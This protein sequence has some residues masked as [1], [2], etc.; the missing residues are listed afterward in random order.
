MSNQQIV[1][2]LSLALLMFGIRVAAVAGD[3][4]QI[5]GPHRNGTAVGEGAVAPWPKT[6]PKKLWSS[7]LGTGFAGPA[8]VGNRVVAFHR[9]GSKERV[10]CFEVDSGKSLW[11]ADFP[12][13][14]P[15]GVNPDNG[16]RC[17]PVV[18]QDRVF[19]FG[20]AGE[21]HCVALSDGRKLWSRDTYSDYKGQVGYFGAGATPIV[22]A[23]KLLVNVGGNNAGI[24]AFDIQTGK[25]AWQATDERAS[26]S[27]PTTATIDGRPHVVFV[28]RLR[29][30]AIDPATGKVLFELPFGKTGPTVNAA[31]PLVLGENLF[32]SASYGVGARLLRLGKS[33]Q[34]IWSND[35]T[36]SSQYSTSVYRDGDLYGIHGREDYSNGELRC[37]EAATGKVRWQVPGFGVGSLI[38]VGDRLVILT[39]DGQLVLAAA[40]RDKYTEL[41]RAAVSTDVTRSLPAISNGRFFFRD[42]N[43]TGGHLTCLTLP[44]SPGAK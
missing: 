33:P 20:A 22:A 4:P 9:I 30:L 15:G 32:L 1:V 44:T 38:L 3:W 17:V 14:Y 34:E 31:T 16:P 6:G 2:R 21:L 35:E 29:C 11:Q 24:V 23:E 27:S 41:A 42:N 40:N 12:G 25:T 26:Y 36:M 39:T 19:V 37:V 13:S 7:E 5:L 28:T 43:D 18:H 8:V 10:E